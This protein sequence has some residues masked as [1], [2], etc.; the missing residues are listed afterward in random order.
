MCICYTSFAVLR[1]VPRSKCANKAALLTARSAGAT[2]IDDGRV[3]DC[4]VLR[5]KLLELVLVDI[6]R[7]LADVELGCAL[8]AALGALGGAV[9]DVNLS[10]G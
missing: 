8:A 7:Q 6:E 5:E 4:A 9:L 1:R 2:I 10:R 3:N